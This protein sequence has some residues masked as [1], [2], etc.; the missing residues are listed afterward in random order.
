MV[1][2]SS[3]CRCCYLPQL[4]VL[5]YCMAAIYTCR[6]RDFNWTVPIS[7]A[8]VVIAFEKLGCMVDMC[9]MGLQFWLQKISE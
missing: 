4:G 6:S 8:T 2:T 7:G 3:Q 5:V 1:G 9:M